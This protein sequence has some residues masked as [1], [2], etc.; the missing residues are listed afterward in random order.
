MKKLLGFI[1]I[2]GFLI[3]YCSCNKQPF[4]TETNETN[5]KNEPITIIDPL[6]SSPDASTKEKFIS[7]PTLCQ[8]PDLPT[9]CEAVAATMVLNFYNINITP[10]EFAR[11]WIEHSEDFY[12]SNGKLY[13]PDPNKVFA[14]NPFTN[15]SY[16][17]FSGAIALA[18]NQKNSNCTA[19]AITDQSL[20]QLCKEYIDREQPLLIWATMGMK[21]S[22]QG[23]TWH[24][25]NGKE[26]TWIAGEHCLVLVGYNDDYYFF[27]DPIS[28]SNVAYQKHIVEKRFAELSNQ[29]VYISLQKT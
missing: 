18:I 10:Q 9:G 28:G 7:V 6:M 29:A 21:K 3:T 4:L 12:Y 19:K 17:C 15:N 1:L 2:A 24:L 23:N 13:G 8:F 11:N 14:G 5:G 22:S 16:G 27:N 25:N 26:F 20:E